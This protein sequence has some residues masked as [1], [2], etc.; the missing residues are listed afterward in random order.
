MP[1][2]HCCFSLCQNQELDFIGQCV[3]LHIKGD[4]VPTQSFTRLL[5][6]LRTSLRDSKGEDIGVHQRLLSQ[7]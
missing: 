3:S 2:H 6:S 1:N 4:T 5:A 7:A